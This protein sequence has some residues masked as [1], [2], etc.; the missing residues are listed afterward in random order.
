MTIL[1]GAL[2]TGANLVYS[3]PTSAGKTLVAE[4]IVLKRVLEGSKRRKALF[5]LPFVAVA[6]EKMLSLQ[7][8][9]SKIY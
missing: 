5:I 7:V 1:T 9:L 3:A 4:L 2:S 6:R 8:Y